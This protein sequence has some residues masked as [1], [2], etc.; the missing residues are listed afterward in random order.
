MTGA[1]RLG[2]V[3]AWCCAGGSLRCGGSDAARA[4]DG[5]DELR[6]VRPTPAPALRV[7]AFESGSN[8][9]PQRLPPQDRFHPRSL[10]I[11]RDAVPLIPSQPSGEVEAP[12]DD[13]LPELPV[14]H[15]FKVEH[16]SVR[17][18]LPHEKVRSLFQT[19]DGALWVGT[20]G[21]LVRIRGARLE[22][23]SEANTPAMA[24]V[25]HVVRSI[26]EDAE[27]AVWLGTETGLLRYRSGRF[28][29]MHPSAG[30]SFVN[31]IQPSG[32]GGVWVGADRG[33]AHVGSGGVEWH[34]IPK[35]TRVH[36]IQEGSDGVLWVGGNGGVVGWDP[37]GRRVVR[38]YLTG[39]VV[40]GEDAVVVVCRGLVLDGDGCL[41]M[42]TNHGLWR[43]STR[44]PGAVPRNDRLAVGPLPIV[45]PRLAGGGGGSVWL[46]DSAVSG[47]LMVFEREDEGF[48]VVPVPIRLTS[49][50]AL[51]L[52]RSGSAWIGARQGLYRVRPRHFRAVTL[53]PRSQEYLPFR[54]VAEAADGG[55]WLSA[56]GLLCRWRGSELWM[57]QTSSKAYIGRAT[58]IPGFD[59]R[60]AVAAE[61]AM[62]CMVDAD[63]LEPAAMLRRLGDFDEV[64][65]VDAAARVPGHG[66][67][68]G[69]RRG[70]FRFGED[71]AV[72]RVE[73]LGERAVL[74]LAAVAGGGGVWVAAEGSGIAH[75]N[76]SSMTQVV[77]RGGVGRIT[78]MVAGEGG[79]LWVGSDEGFGVL[80]DG[81]FRRVPLD[82]P[83][84][85]WPV[86]SIL[87]DSRGDLW[88]NGGDGVVRMQRAH[89][90][91]VVA[92]R[93]DRVV[94]TEYGVDEGV[95][96]GGSVTG[97]QTALEASDGRLWFVK[98]NGLAVVDPAG[99]P[100]EREIPIPRLDSVQA[101]GE[102]VGLG[103]IPAG[104]RVVFGLAASETPFPK[105]L[106]IQYRLDGVDK[107]WHEAGGGGRAVYPVLPAGRHLLRVRART[108]TSAWS[109]PAGA[110]W[111]VV[112]VGPWWRSGW[113]VGGLG[114]V[115]VGAVGTALW[116]RSRRKERRV[117][118]EADEALERERLRIARELHDHLGPRIA[119]L[120]MQP[121]DV[122]E[123]HSQV[124]S[125]LGELNEMIWSTHPDHDRLSS[126]ADF[127]GDFA[128]RYLDA[129]GL[130]LELDIAPIA[131]D[132][133]IRSQ[134][135]RELAA[136]FKEAL[137]NTV[138]HARASRV[139][140]GLGV[141]P[142]EMRLSLEDDGQGVEDFG[143]GRAGGGLGQFGARMKALG[144]SCEIE[145]G[146]GR[147]TRVEFRVP[148]DGLRVKRE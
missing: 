51:H 118:R 24:E 102:G 138:Q 5:V 57:L 64:G 105:G 98:R 111:P 69:S 49:P 43:V 143:K 41:W 85:V 3:L 63:A 84:T 48:Q 39:R 90:E 65:D 128:S 88:L 121:R 81:A 140:V 112:V 21:G 141:G 60:M 30:L 148:L 12:S 116:H 62:G 114:L 126:L 29:V 4:P 2:V 74:A 75:W 31:A 11:G 123:A 25:G 122:E 78:A 129:A 95:M 99:L 20:A 37:G 16:W 134:A 80:R 130:E 52:D 132:E 42:G 127:V 145:T 26:G 19:R 124:R 34:P 76:G 83:S 9:K 46:V 100:R 32:R 71:G 6:P 94:T 61:G 91:A 55:V 73:A 7:R 35:L 82:V 10:E 108:W 15:D 18:G 1:A 93:A 70:L 92:G 136:L 117:R 53:E 77:E 115:G 139:K 47:A 110:S 36:T 58:L 27:G 50:T 144:G 66:W 38:E 125:T 106:R 68:L 59:G 86:S 79:R 104:V 87:E 101:D 13:G 119:I 120:S 146:P 22:V 142:N 8:L 44:D 107:A 97:F 45:D 137:R 103:A 135:R 28:E 113:A 72:T 67:Y 89:L 23:F 33:L 109:D 133:V 56:A 54:A 96:H 40:V 14:H 131:R 147:G 17:D